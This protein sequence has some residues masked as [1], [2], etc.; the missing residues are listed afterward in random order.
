MISIHLTSINTYLPF[1]SFL[2][3]FNLFLFLKHSFNLCFLKH[4]FFTFW[5]ASLLKHSNTWCF[6]ELQN[7]VNLFFFYLWKMEALFFFFVVKV[8]CVMFFMH[9]LW[10]H[11]EPKHSWSWR[12][13]DIG[14]DLLFLV[15]ELELFFLLFFCHNYLWILFVCGLCLYRWSTHFNCETSMWIC[16]RLLIP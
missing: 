1:P 2:H 15:Y 10:I 4:S 11:V 16:K 9:G 3:L 12:T 13:L 6:K 14:P 5:V 7:I 8:F